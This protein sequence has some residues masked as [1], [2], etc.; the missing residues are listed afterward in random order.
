VYVLNPGKLAMTGKPARKTDREDARKIARFIQRYPEEELPLAEEGLEGCGAAGA[1]ARERACDPQLPV[2]AL[3]PGRTRKSAL[4][5]CFWR[6]GATGRASGVT[7]DKPG[8]RG[9]ATTIYNIICKKYLPY[10]ITLKIVQPLADNLRLCYIV[11]VNFVPARRPRFIFAICLVL[12]VMGVFAFAATPDIA[13]FD[14]LKNK[15][16]DGSVISANTD[17]TIDRF[18]E[19]KNKTKGDSTLSLRRSAYFILLF[20]R[21]CVGIAASVLVIR[22]ARPIKAPSSKSTLLLKLRI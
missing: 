7:S 11:S 6:G 12:S 9:V 14:F 5:I 20:G 10:Y 4:R 17:Y 22:V 1:G 15:L 2:T 21:L 19:F 3:R 18:A 16:I 13:G 8:F